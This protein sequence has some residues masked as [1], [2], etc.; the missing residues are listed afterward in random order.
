MQ[1]AAL[2]AAVKSGQDV[3]SVVAQAISGAA[4][5]AQR[6]T[7][8]ATRVIVALWRSTDP[9]DQ[10][11]VAKFV[12]QAGRT[13]VA[14]QKAVA[15]T[16]A[17]A[18]MAQL[19]ALGINTKVAVTI[20]DD[21]RGAH[22]RL[23]ETSA[24]VKPKP[25]VTV[26]YKTSDGETDREVTKSDSAPD[27]VFN[28]A[29]VTYQYERSQG[30]DHATAN[31]AA[32]DRIGLIVDGNVTLAQ[33]L[34]E[35]QTLAKVHAIDERVIGWRRV[36]HP[37]LSKGGVCGLCVAASDRVYGVKELK[38]IHL[39]CKCSVSPVTKSKDPGQ[40]LNS[41]DLG[42]LYDDAGKSTDTAALKRTRYDV[43]H[44]NELGPVLTRVQG[45]KVPYYSTT[46]PAKAA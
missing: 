35:Q 10:A 43:V 25:K 21:V 41:Q 40:Q 12:Q 18:Q 46:P 38:P 19:Q 45:E 22:V 2:L 31:T 26:T 1:A 39:R 24:E 27:Q 8:T 14:A 15:S 28:R 20:P 5:A 37:E 16:A 13:I 33:R 17:A 42:R 4:A 23:G 44:H 30:A 7:D 36:I 34:G 11:A 6:A 29:V 3:T 32:E 9:A